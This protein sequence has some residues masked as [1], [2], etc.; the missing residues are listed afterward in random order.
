M[1][2]ISHFLLIHLAEG[3]GLYISNKHIK[4]AVWWNIYLWYYTSI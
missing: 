3:K 4:D 2:T 1:F